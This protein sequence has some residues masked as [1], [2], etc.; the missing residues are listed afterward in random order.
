MSLVLI[1]LKSL[2]LVSLPTFCLGLD[3][4]GV[5]LALF[6]TPIG[7]LLLLFMFTHVQTFSANAEMFVRFKVFHTVTT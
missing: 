7:F 2:Q 3:E 5:V 1:F 6:L 4:K